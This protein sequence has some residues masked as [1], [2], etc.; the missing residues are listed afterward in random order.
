MNSSAESKVEVQ[1]TDKMLKEF[2][3]LLPK[4]GAKESGSIILSEYLRDFDLKPVNDTY[5]KE[6]AIVYFISGPAW[7][8][9]DFLL[10]RSW[11]KGFESACAQAGRHL[12]LK[13]TIDQYCVSKFDSPLPKDEE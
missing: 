2:S 10:E 11:L 1:V 5:M 13:F 4:H 12:N 7:R 8:Q 3:Y 6:Q 9:D